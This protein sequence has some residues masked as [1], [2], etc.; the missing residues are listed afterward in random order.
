MPR[1]LSDLI[2]SLFIAV[3]RFRSS[4]KR[5]QAARIVGRVFENPANQYQE[6]VTNGSQWGTF[7]LG[8][9]YFAAK[10]LWTHAAAL[11]LLTLATVSIGAFAWLLLFLIWI[12]YTIVTPDLLAS[13]YLKR[14]WREVSATDTDADRNEDNEAQRPQQTDDKRLC[15]F[16][17]ET[18]KQKALVCRFCGRDLQDE[19][20]SKRTTA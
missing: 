16:C 12:G 17:A 20:V 9:I 8:P 4:P 2:D 1:R 6:V 18:I 11:V 10:G 15:P 3:G 7:W 5:R 19:S 13:N 14:G